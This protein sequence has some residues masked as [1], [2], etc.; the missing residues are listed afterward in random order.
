MHAGLSAGLV[1]KSC[2]QDPKRLWWKDVKSKRVGKGQCKNAV[3]HIVF[4]FEGF[5]K[6]TVL[7]TKVQ[8]CV[9]FDEKYFYR[10]LS[11]IYSNLDFINSINFRYNKWIKTVIWTIKQIHA[12]FS[13]K[14]FIGTYPY[15]TATLIYYLF[16]NNKKYI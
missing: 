15:L 4:R 9:I 10:R 13:Y 1:L 3:D 12:E 8:V 6:V 7:R 5:V 11:E 2:G 16:D 14:Y